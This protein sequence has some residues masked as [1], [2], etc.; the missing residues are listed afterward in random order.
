[1]SVL[2][3]T[4]VEQSGASD[5][6][7]ESAMLAEERRKIIKMLTD[8]ADLKFFSR[9]TQRRRLEDIEQ[10]LR[11]ALL[12]NELELECRQAPSGDVAVA[13]DATRGALR[14]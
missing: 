11:F 2:L 10:T 12:Q 8:V 1:V 6:T 13:L 9:G 4:P 14:R 5:R 3:A 7:P